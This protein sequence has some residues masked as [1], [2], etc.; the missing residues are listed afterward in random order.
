MY[1][2]ELDRDAHELTQLM[3]LAAATSQEG[4]DDD[5]GEGQRSRSED[6]AGVTAEFL[7]HIAERLRR[8][9]TL[10]GRTIERFV[11]QTQHRSPLPGD[12]GRSPGGSPEHTPVNF[13][14]SRT[15]TCHSAMR[16]LSSHLRNIAHFLT[17]VT[18]PTLQTTTTA[19]PTR[20]PTTASQT[21]T[22]SVSVDWEELGNATG[23]NVTTN[24]TTTI[25]P[26]AC[27]TPSRS[28]ECPHSVTAATT[29]RRVTH[30]LDPSMDW[31]GLDW[32][33]SGF[34][35]NFMDWIGFGGMTMTTFLISNHCSTG[36]DFFLSYCDL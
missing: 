5:D 2:S 3:L 4:D 14:G 32:I 13:T 34:S 18:A 20:P 15:R 17:N 26:C 33:G 25:P 11:A 30:G 7:L 22:S 28:F 6:D 31:I 36:D 9:S 10:A 21:A 8:K 29:H 35:E 19:V 24:V 23:W 27:P 12:D 1:L 16:R